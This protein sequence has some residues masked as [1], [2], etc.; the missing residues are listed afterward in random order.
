[1]PAIQRQI[2]FLTSLELRVLLLLI[3]LIIPLLPA[4]STTFTTLLIYNNI[5]YIQVRAS[6]LWLRLRANVEVI[7]IFTL[8]SNI[9]NRLDNVI[10]NFN[11]QKI[12]I[13]I[14]KFIYIIKFINLLLI[15][16]VIQAN[17][18]KYIIN[19]NIKL[20]NSLKLYIYIKP[21]AYFI[22][23]IKGK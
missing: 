21:L 1:M 18:L 19:K 3:I 5:I 20:L 17:L 22:N 7:T 8:I 4:I 16:K 15:I 14:V 23:I 6:Q 13:L 11:T 10:N 12:K 9:I 2:Q